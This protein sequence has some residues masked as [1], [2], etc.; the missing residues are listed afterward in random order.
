MRFSNMPDYSIND[1][2][3]TSTTI[4]QASELEVGGFAVRMGADF[5]RSGHKTLPDSG[6]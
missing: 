2:V 3:A 4:S 5:W 6:A 1:G